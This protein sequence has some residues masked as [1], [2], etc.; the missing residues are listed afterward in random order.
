[1]WGSFEK[2]YYWIGEMLFFYVMDRLEVVDIDEEC[3]FEFVEF[4][5]NKWIQELVLDEGLKV[6]CFLCR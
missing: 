3:D 4:L 5:M 2:C 6:V 1:M